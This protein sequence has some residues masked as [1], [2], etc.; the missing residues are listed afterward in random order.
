MPAHTASIVPIAPD[1]DVFARL[2]KLEK[3]LDATK[4][5]A[6]VTT[7]E[8]ERARG[9]VADTVKGTRVLDTSTLRKIDHD[10]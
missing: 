10:P 2:R 6:D 1:D 5:S 4:A 3:E 9:I 7:K 8:V